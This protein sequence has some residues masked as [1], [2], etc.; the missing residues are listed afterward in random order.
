MVYIGNDI[1]DFEVMKI[2]GFP[3]APADAHPQIK[4]IV[5]VVTRAKG[6]EGVIR[7]LLDKVLQEKK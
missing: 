4:K 2:V 7:E 3:I 1:N 5:K 6:G